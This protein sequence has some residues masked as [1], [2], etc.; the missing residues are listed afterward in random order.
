MLAYLQPAYNTDFELVT[1]SALRQIPESN[2]EKKMPYS[3]TTA[4]R[5]PVEPVSAVLDDA[6]LGDIHG[7][8]GSIRRGYVA[9]RRTW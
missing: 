8:F 7:A 6:H 9:P 4:D 3:T 5:L 2:Q 1:C